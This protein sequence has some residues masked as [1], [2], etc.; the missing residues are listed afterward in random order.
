[1]SRSTILSLSLVGFLV[2]SGCAKDP[3][4][5]T[6]ATAGL[7][8]QPRLARHELPSVATKPD[9]NVHVDLVRTSADLQ[10][11]YGKLGLTPP[12]DVD[13]GSQT[14][15][16]REAL[17]TQPIAWIVAKDGII[18]IGSQACT[19]AANGTCSVTVFAVDAALTKAE[20]YTCEEIGCSGASATI[21]AEG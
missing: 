7:G 14:V 10:V 18:T 12:S 9:C 2:I 8:D 21:G 13:F 17:D 20:A 4:V 11:A 5:C 16:I 1:M 6:P 3:A 15:V 19:G